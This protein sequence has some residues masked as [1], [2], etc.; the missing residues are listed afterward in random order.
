MGFLRLGAGVSLRPYI[1]RASPYTRW[2]VHLGAGHR[3]I[4]IF[5]VIALEEIGVPLPLPGDV[6]IAYAG[7]LVARGKIG[8][9]T[10]FFTI[11]AGSMVGAS[12]LYYVARHYG[13]P[14]VRRYGPYMH[15]KQKRLEM[16]ERWFVKWGPVVI[17]LG[18]QIPGLRM[19]ISVFA[20]VFG[21]PYRT[22]LASVTLAGAIWAGMF[23]YIGYKFDSHLGQYMTVTPVHLL[24]STLFIS[25][26]IL[27]GL[28]LKR[29]AVREDRR[30]EALAEAKPR[31]A[32]SKARP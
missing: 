15:I 14:F 4:S 6:F 17:V 20:G 16:V 31:L 5:L 7:H 28:Y 21:V 27:Y 3:A 12:V 19:V 22:F 25:F 9:A 23:L 2:L 24:P 11:V 29:K 30:L 10:A 8:A 18:R 13:Q 26:T 32:G 1:E